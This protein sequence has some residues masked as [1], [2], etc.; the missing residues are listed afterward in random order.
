MFKY[1]P[2]K[3]Q[4]Q[5]PFKVVVFGG[6]IEFHELINDFA[7]LFL[8]NIP[9]YLKKPFVFYPIPTSKNTIAEYIAKY[10]VWYHRY[11]YSPFL[12]LKLIP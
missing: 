12:N 7:H 3:I 5:L 10:D 8:D 9:G 2:F 6:D 11:I 4:N 1:N